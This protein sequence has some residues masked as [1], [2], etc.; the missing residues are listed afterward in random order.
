MA[1]VFFNDAFFGGGYFQ[2]LV[3]G[4]TVYYGVGQ[5]VYKRK[6]KKYDNQILFADI[7]KSLRLLVYGPVVSDDGVVPVVDAPVAVQD[8]SSALETLRHLA[9]GRQDLQRRLASLRRDLQSV[10]AE[11]RQR[12]QDDEEEIMMVL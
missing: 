12:E 7:E 10:A 3:S 1:G 11:Q 8:I 6:R 4:P 5:P 9:E 2:T